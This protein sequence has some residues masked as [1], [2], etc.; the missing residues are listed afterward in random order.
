MK[1]LDL[2][3]GLGGWSAAFKARGHDIITVDNEQSFNPNICADIMTLSAAQFAQFGRFDLI[4]ASPPCECFSVASISS[5]WT[6]GIGAYI[7]KTERT[8]NAIKLVKH[9]LIMIQDLN[10]KYWIM[11]NPRG[12]LRKIIGLPKTT[13]TYCQYGERRMKPTDL[14]GELPPS[15]ISKRCFNGD[16]CH[17][18]APR[19]SK[20]GTQGIKYAIFRSKIPYGLS[21]AVCLATEKDLADPPGPASF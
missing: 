11:E 14:W 5:N 17:D 1:V 20:T 12:V 19:G 16:L 15:F 3:S 21:L 8:K 6:G 13:I 2:F 4:L 10:P 7:P 9:T 18:S